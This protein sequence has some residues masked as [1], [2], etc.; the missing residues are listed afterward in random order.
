MDTPETKA[1]AIEKLRAALTPVRRAYTHAARIDSLKR[2]QG[3]L[4]MLWS[5]EWVDKETVEA[6]N[7]EILNADS[8][9]HRHCEAKIALGDQSRCMDDE[10]MHDRAR[11]L[12]ALAESEFEMRRAPDLKALEL[13]AFNIEDRLMRGW[14]AYLDDQDLMEWRVAI[15]FARTERTK[16]LE[17]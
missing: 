2:A 8:E 10:F 15:H 11:E 1:K 13:H 9:G 14:P 7:I 6:L 17:S 16:Q 5:I 3:M 12:M 4:F